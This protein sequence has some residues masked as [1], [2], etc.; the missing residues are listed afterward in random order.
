MKKMTL[1]MGL[2]FA[3][4]SMAEAATTYQISKEW[5][6]SH[7]GSGYLSEIPAFDALTNTLWVAGVKGVDVLNA[8]NGN[9]LQ[10]IDTSAYGNINSVSI[11]NGLAAFAIENTTR[12]NAG[13]VQLYD[14]T[15]RSLAAGTN[16]F[17]VG[18]LPD[19]LTFT[20]DGTK[21]L[22]ANEGTPD[23]YGSRIGSSVPRVYGAPANDPAGSVT[24]ID[25]ASRSVS[26]TATLAGVPTSGSHIRT[27]TGMDFE[28]EYIAV[29]ADGSKA[30]VTL[31]E[32]N[33][34]GVLDLKTQSFT[35]VVGL[36][37][38]DF[39]A[40]GNSIDPLNN[41]SVSFISPNVKG[42]YMPDGIAT[43]DVAGVTYLVTANEG[44]FRED[45]GDRSAASG[46]GGSGALANI[47]VSNTDSSVGDLY[48]AGARSFSIRD[49]DGNLVY[50]SGDILDKEA[51]ARGIYDD[52]RSRDKGVE[53]EGVDLF[54]LGGRTIAAVGLERTLKGAIALFDITDPTKVSF[55]DMIV[56]EGD[57]APEGLVAFEKDGAVFLAFAN[58]ASNTTSLFRVS[59]VPEP[60][61]AAMLGLGLVG[62]AAM[63]RRQQ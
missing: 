40:P 21:I 44:D 24:I 15:S 23:T 59:A 52:A 10:R 27:N 37:V 2:L 35:K 45:D 19:M 14:T 55:I 41:N 25:V 51:F 33:A 47:R 12:S 9:L 58:E 53:P 49:A 16:S 42:L 18:A 39:S 32:A 3:S 56:S 60:G 26:A 57:L 5:T 28:P 46:L 29:S 34:I 7:S 6:F 63:R 17:N 8:T 30:Y 38:K 1:V 61:S 4:M 50:D 13:I 48:A 36:G 43:Y 11:H 22:V 54:T 20:P 62:I 31:Q